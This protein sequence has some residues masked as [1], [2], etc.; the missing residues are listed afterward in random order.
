LRLVLLRY[1][2]R[3][4]SMAPPFARPTCIRA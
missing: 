2:L 3:V 4:G 1:N